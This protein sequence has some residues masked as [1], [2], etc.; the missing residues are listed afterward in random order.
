MAAIQALTVGHALDLESARTGVVHSV[1]AR[2]VNCEIGADLW[3]LLAA[4]RADLPFG[5]RVAADDL[6]PLCLRRGEPV[7]VAS[8]FV[9]IGSGAGHLVVDA[10]AAPRW[11]PTPHGPLAPGVA[12]RLAAVAAVAA[13][14]A[15]QGSAGLAHAVV[16]A[17]NDRDTLGRALRGVVGC[18]PGASPAGDDVL[19]GILALLASPHSGARGATAAHSLCRALLPLLPRTTDIS[20]HLLRQAASG[21]FGRPVHELV[22]AVIADQGSPH[23]KESLRRVVET[24]ATSGADLCIG[25]LACAPAF[26]PIHYERA[27]A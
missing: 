5:I 27:E 16:S 9:G 3:T 8:G 25:L 24:G 18:G 23:L 10:R 13:P 17:L 12:E 26:L 2:A 14:R 15:W 1:F 11:I 21:L 6:G 4:D 19:A 7:S 20:G 22:C